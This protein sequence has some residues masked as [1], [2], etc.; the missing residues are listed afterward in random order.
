MPL[1]DKIVLITGG[2]RRIG[3]SLALAVARAGGDVAIHY[4]QSHGEA[5]STRGEVEALGRKAFL[6]QAD[7]SDP[8]QAA[9]LIPRVLEHGRL[10][11]LVNNASVFEPLT[12]KKDGELKEAGNYSL[13]RCGHSKDKPYCDGAHN[14][15]EFDGTETADTRPSEA[16]QEIL[17]EGTGIV[18]KKDVYL[19]MDSGFCGNRLTNIDEMVADTDEPRVRAEIIGIAVLQEFSFRL[20]AARA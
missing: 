19:C 17:D 16:R 10:Y 14:D 12:W 3:R 13:C 7:L 18:V 4:W 20:R 1:D 8:L 5:D 6:L 15:I 2:A 9:G 11:A